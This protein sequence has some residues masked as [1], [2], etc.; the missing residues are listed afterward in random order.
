M[1][2]VFQAVSIAIITVEL[3]DTPDIALTVMWLACLKNIAWK[4]AQRYLDAAG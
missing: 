1:E 4:A 2:T 3:I